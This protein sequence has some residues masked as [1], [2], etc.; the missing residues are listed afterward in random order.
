[1]TEK[2]AV[3]V[4]WHGGELVF[5][6]R[7]EGGIVRYALPGGKLEAGEKTIDATVREVE[8]EIGY[9]F[10]EEDFGELS[11]IRIAGF[12]GYFRSARLPYGTVLKPRP[13][14]KYQTLVLW[15]AERIEEAIEEEIFMPLTGAYLEKNLL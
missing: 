7:E 5:Q 15:G 8:Q 11:V 4:I 13:E 3:G 10:R 6:E 9:R 12:A 1:M 14:E 2:V